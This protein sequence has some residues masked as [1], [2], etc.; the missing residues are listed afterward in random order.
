MPHV[1]IIYIYISV[2]CHSLGTSMSL[3]EG[4]SGNEGLPTPRMDPKCTPST[5]CFRRQRGS[6][7]GNKADGETKALALWE[8]HVVLRRPEALCC[9]RAQLRQEGAFS[10]QTPVHRGEK[11]TP[12]IPW[13]PGPGQAGLLDTAWEEPPED[14]ARQ[15]QSEG[16]SCR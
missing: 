6:A 4:L 2:Q 9:H 15:G 16:A 11:E 3:S 8:G 13:P 1:Y 7:G 12:D 10:S 5:L 14:P